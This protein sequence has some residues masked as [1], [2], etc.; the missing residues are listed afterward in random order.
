MEKRSYLFSYVCE[1]KSNSL[2]SV[3][4]A[5]GRRCT[6]FVLQFTMTVS[7]RSRLDDWCWE[8][9]L[10]LLCSALVPY[11]LNGWDNFGFYHNCLYCDCVLFWLQIDEFD[12]W[13]VKYCFGCLCVGG[14]FGWWTGLLYW[15]G[16]GRNLWVF[17]RLLVWM[18]QADWKE[19]CT[20]EIVLCFEFVCRFS[21]W[22][23]APL[24]MNCSF[25]FIAS[26]LGF[27]VC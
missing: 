27:R 16:V 19:L 12:E 17:E 25:L 23:S 3:W 22:S 8:R 4:F 11:V 9:W 13:L 26:V 7:M 6:L 2:L 21:R 24:Q 10:L 18:M 14:G 20:C 15:I 5:L 1:D